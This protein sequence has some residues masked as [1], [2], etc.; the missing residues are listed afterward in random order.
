MMSVTTHQRD[1]SPGHYL[2]V[3]A[4]GCSCTG[5][6]IH[7][8]HQLIGDANVDECWASEPHPRTR[9]FL[10]GNYEIPVLYQD[11]SGARPADY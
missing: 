8:F 6:P 5:G 7:A 10:L 1:P 11:I 2:Q 4:T 9:Q 3:V